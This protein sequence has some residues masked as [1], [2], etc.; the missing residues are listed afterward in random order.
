VTNAALVKKRLFLSLYPEYTALANPRTEP[1]SKKAWDDFHT[2]LEKG[3]RWLHLREETNL[4]IFALI[5][6]SVSNR[7][8]EKELPFDVFRTWV[9]LI[10]QCNQPAIA[11]G[12]AMLPGLQYALSG[13]TMPARK[14]RLEITDVEDLKDYSDTSVLFQEVDES[15]A[16]E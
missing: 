2:K 7:W 9:R 8:I 13:Q 12:K 5:P 15:S 1:R 14:I 16:G 3:R 11:L 4:G 10:H 6:D